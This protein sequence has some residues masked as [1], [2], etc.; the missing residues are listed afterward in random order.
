MPPVPTGRSIFILR[1]LMSILPIL[2]HWLPRRKRVM[3]DVMAYVIILVF[4]SKSLLPILLR[5]MRITSRSE[6]MVG[7]CS[8]R[9]DT[10]L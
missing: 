8:V 2:K 3:S 9:G 1:Y 7:R 4:P 6:R 5:S 10:G